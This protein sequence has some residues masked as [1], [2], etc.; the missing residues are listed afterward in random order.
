MQPNKLFNYRLSVLTPHVRAAVSDEDSWG[1]VGIEA[2]SLISHAVDLFE[3]DLKGSAQK[4]LD[5]VDE[6]LDMSS[7]PGAAR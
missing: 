2:A 5:K 3:R 7:Y 4:T 1:E 6:L